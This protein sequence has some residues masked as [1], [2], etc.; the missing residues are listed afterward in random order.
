MKKNQIIYK[1]FAAAVL[2]ILAACTDDRVKPTIPDSSAF[3]A[4]SL[5]NPTTSAAVT[6]KAEDANKVFENFEWQPT[7]YGVSLSTNYVLEV[8]KTQDFSKPQKLAETSTHSA[9]VSVE[10]LDNAMLALGLPGFKESTVFIRLKSTANGYSKDP[11]TGTDVAPL[12]SAV[13]SR[14]ATT[15]QNSECGKFCTVGIIGSATPGGWDIDTDLHLAD[16][17][18]DKSTWTTVLYLSAG[19]VKFRAMDDWATNWGA[20][21]FPTGTGTQNGDNIPVAT[22]GYY[23]VVFN[24]GTGAYTFTPQTTP[25]LAKVGIIGSGTAGGWDTDTDLTK[26]PNNPHVWT[27]TVV[28]TAG[29]AKFR[30][31]HDWGTNWGGKTYPSGYGI[32]GGDNIAV[33]AGAYFVYFNDAT[34]DYFF[35]PANRGT[36]FAKVGLIGTAQSGGWDTDTDLVKNPANPYLWSKIVAVKDGEGKFRANHDWAVNWGASPFPQGVAADGGPNI[37]TKGGTY[38]ITFN[39]GTGEYYFLK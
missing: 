34:G 39:S 27:G 38:F 4:P 28:L 22:A 12:Y 24:D 6:L 13:I 17:K 35:A 33:K 29:E 11:V 9:T 16:A 26:D 14:T 37:P 7:D 20:K 15:Y 5:T 30:A 18:T 19:E 3:V 1:L 8:D 25:V 36:P 23:K 21:G 10:A 2:V 31:N 32:G